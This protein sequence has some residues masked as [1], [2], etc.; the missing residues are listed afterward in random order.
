MGECNGGAGCMR[1]V[2]SLTTLPVLYPLWASPLRR[3][4][5]LSLGTSTAHRRSPSTNAA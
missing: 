3:Y 1:S 4:V 5:Q 2:S